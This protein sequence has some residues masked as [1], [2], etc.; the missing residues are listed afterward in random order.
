MCGDAVCGAR[1]K[2]RVLIVSDFFFPAVGG[3]ESHIYHLSHC[4]GQQGHKGAVSV[5]AAPILQT[6][7][8]LLRW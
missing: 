7:A 1:A 8:Q 4:L 6:W 5:G 2:H 3:V